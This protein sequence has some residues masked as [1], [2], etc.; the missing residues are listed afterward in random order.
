MNTVPGL[1]VTVPAFSLTVRRTTSPV[2]TSAV[3]PC[4][5]S[6]EMLAQR[7]SLS[8]RIFMD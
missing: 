6:I 8:G 1:R 7:P 2:R 3:G 4:G 5:V